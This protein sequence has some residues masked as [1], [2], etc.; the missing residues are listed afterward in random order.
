MKTYVIGKEDYRS[1]SDVAYI[2]SFTIIQGQI[3]VTLTEESQLAHKFFYRQEGL[4][5]VK[6]I[7]N[8]YKLMVIK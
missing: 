8:D 2:Q 7:N 4:K 6:L 1:R 3:F 5:I